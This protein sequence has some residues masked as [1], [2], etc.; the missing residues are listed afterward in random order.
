MSIGRKGPDVTIPAGE[1]RHDLGTTS[2]Q[3][4]IRQVVLSLGKGFVLIRN[5]KED[6]W[7]CRVGAL[8]IISQEERARPLEKSE[9]P[10]AIELSSSKERKV[11]EKKG[12]QQ[13]NAPN[14]EVVSSDIVS[15]K[16]LMLAQVLPPPSSSPQKE[17]PTA[18]SQRESNAKV[19]IGIIAR[20]DE[21][22]IGRTLAR[23]Q[24]LGGK[25]VV[26]D[27]ESTDS[28]EDIVSKMGETLLKHPRQVGMSDSVKSLILEARASM[29]DVLL[30]Y[31][32]R[33]PNST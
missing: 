1:S 24:S 6:N 26:C 20:N 32:S 8:E 13:A 29:P 17:E 19:I 15:G 28:T 2:A 27:D 11:I 31:S 25:I 12:D 10:K 18:I 16:S 9:D 23:L 30:T 21:T 7:D 5:I 22:S 3:E 4:Q 14:V 33:I